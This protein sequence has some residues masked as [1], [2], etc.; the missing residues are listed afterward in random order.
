MRAEGAPP[1]LP[2]RDPWRVIMKHCIRPALPAALL[3][4]F[5]LSATSAWAG[6]TGV[7]GIND[8]AINGIGG[9]GTVSCTSVLPNYV[10]PL[11]M[12]FDVYTAPFTPVVYAFNTCACAADTI[13]FAPVTCALPFTSFAATTNQS[14]D[15][16]TCPL[17][18]AVAISDSTGHAVLTGLIPKVSATTTVGTQAAVIG[19][20]CGLPSSFVLT[21]AHTLT[22]I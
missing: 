7:F 2:N 19:L 10:T 15:L 13:Y 18:I 4:A 21:Q 17:I 6:V 12:T 14:F 9:A 5:S 16:A 22:F 20:P 1:R 8:Y 3:L 11:A